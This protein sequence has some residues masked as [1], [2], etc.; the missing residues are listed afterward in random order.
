MNL[1]NWI[2]SGAVATLVLIALLQWVVVLERCWAALWQWYKFAGYGDGGYITVGLFTQIAFF[3]VSIVIASVGFVLSHYAENAF[4]A[5]TSKLA[6]ISLLA[7]ILV[8]AGVLVSP[9]AVFR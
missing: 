5:V 6:A 4:L 9:L 8:W 2:R 7:G 1:T 3:V